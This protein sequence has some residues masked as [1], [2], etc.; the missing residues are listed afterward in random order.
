MFQVLQY[1]LPCSSNIYG[2]VPKDASISEPQITLVSVFLKDLYGYNF[3]R[4]TM[5]ASQ[6]DIRE[7]TRLI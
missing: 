3:S 1:D 4:R 2:I 5:T 7:E 6:R